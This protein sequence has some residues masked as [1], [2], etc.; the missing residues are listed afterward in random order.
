MYVCMYVCTHMWHV[1]SPSTLYNATWG[2]LFVF[3]RPAEVNISLC[4]F[5]HVGRNVTLRAPLLTN[6]LISGFARIMFRFY[7]LHLE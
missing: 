2:K 5:V 6:A 1:L 3:F 4:P 7:Y